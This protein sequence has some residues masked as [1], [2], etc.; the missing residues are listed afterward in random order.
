MQSGYYIYMYI[1]VHV[2]EYTCMYDVLGCVAGLGARMNINICGCKM[3]TLAH[4][5][6]KSHLYIYVHEHKHMRVHTFTIGVYI[7]SRISKIASRLDDQ[8]CIHTCTC[9]CENYT[10]VYAIPC[11]QMLLESRQPLIK[12]RVLKSTITLLVKP[13]VIERE[14]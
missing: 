12:L 4:L 10:C 6:C 7:V 8:K 2:C 5:E 11:K 13:N 14:H 9:T 1:H 3:T